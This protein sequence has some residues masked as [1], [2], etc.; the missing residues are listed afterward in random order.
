VAHSLTRFDADTL[1]LEYSGLVGYAER[2]QAVS[3]AAD[4]AANL[5]VKYVLIDFT[6]AVIFEEGTA[7]GAD[8]SAKAIIAWNFRGVCVAFVGIP[9]HYALPGELACQMRHNPARV[10]RRREQALAWFTQRDHDWM[11]TR[12]TPQ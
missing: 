7:Q 12:L 1:L 9:R 2:S 11:S 5:G 3:A 4:Y 6:R 8:F 10:F